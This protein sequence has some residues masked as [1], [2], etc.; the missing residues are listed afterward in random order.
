MAVTMVAGLPIPSTSPLFLAGVVVHVAAAL[1][2]LLAGAGAMLSRKAPGRHPTFG[3]VYF[4]GLAVVAASAL[5][6][7]AA[8]W[9]EDYPLAALAVLA[10]ALATAARWAIR[11]RRVRVHLSAMGASYVTMLTAF[12][13]D[14]GK[15]LPVWR[16]MPPVVYWLGPSIAGAPL[17][18]WALWRRG[19]AMLP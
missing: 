4:W 10:F 18:L 7:A 16:D 19:P 15:F 17:I 13:V 14:N 9:A 12:Y 1:T 8:R 5:A 3:K 6:L 11:G 2:C